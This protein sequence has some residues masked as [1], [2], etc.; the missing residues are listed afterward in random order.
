MFIHNAIETSGSYSLC[1]NFVNN[2]LAVSL[3]EVNMQT[4]CYCTLGISEILNTQFKLFWPS[5]YLYYVIIAN[6]IILAL[7]MNLLWR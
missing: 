6:I 4:L 2:V 3:L 1:D 7:N 5:G